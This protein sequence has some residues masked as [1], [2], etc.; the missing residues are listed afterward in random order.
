MMSTIYKAKWRNNMTPLSWIHLSDLHFGLSYHDDAF[1]NKLLEDIDKVNKESKSQPTFVIITGDI[2]N[3]GLQNEYK[4][5]KLF[6]E[7]IFRQTFK[8]NKNHKR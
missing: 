2:A 5:A 4:A 7:I 8:N 6:G 1:Y 3:A